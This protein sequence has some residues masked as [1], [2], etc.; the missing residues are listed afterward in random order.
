MAGDSAPRVPN[1]PTMEAGGWK[2]G[3][4]RRRRGRRGLRYRFGRGGGGQRG[5]SDDDDDDL[6]IVLGRLREGGAA[7]GNQTGSGLRPGEGRR[8]GHRDRGGP[9][10]QAGPGRPGEQPVQ[11][12]EGWQGGAAREAATEASWGGAR[13]HVR[14]HPND[15]P[16]PD[17]QADLDAL[18]S[19]HRAQGRCLP[20]QAK[21][22]QPIKLPGQTG[23]PRGAQGVPE[24]G[25][26]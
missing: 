7:A 26:R 24:L 12:V 21:P 19:A 25:P 9:P 10:R 4:L 17:G 23:S 15:A 20:S 14:V 2:G 8:Q 16:Q 13:L 3:E 11:V 1:S 5:A 6:D 18:R 22:G